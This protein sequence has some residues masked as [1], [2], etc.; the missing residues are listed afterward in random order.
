LETKN[1]RLNLDWG[2]GSQ[3]IGTDLDSF[4]ANWI[5]ELDPSLHF[6][7]SNHKQALL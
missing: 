3:F 6:G 7:S 4:E 5:L 2:P 1:L